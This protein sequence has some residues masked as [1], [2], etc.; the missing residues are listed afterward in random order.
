[1]SLWIEVATLPR[2]KRALLP[3]QSRYRLHAI[4]DDPFGFV[5][6]RVW[7]AY[8]RGR[9]IRR[10]AELTGRKVH[11][12]RTLRCALFGHDEPWPGSN[13]CSRCQNYGG[14]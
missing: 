13:D 6:W 8:N 3:Q 10:A 12:P 2:W 11:M 1:M 4:S 9:L 5:V 14:V 7:R